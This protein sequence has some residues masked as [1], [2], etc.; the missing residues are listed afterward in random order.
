MYKQP[1]NL[2]WLSPSFI[3]FPSC[4]DSTA[5]DEGVQSSLVS[6]PPVFSSFHSVN[7]DGEICEPDRQRID[8]REEGVESHAMSM[9]SLE[10]G[11][12]C[13]E[14]VFRAVEMGRC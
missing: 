8:T 6:R 4:C 13:K 11:S 7:M 14:A 10:A 9:Q 2:F 12:F 3:S 5:M 1:E